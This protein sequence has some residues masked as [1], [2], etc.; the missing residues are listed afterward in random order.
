[1]FIFF[2]ALSKFLDNNANESGNSQQHS[3]R[4]LSQKNPFSFAAN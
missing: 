2:A 3:Q 4:S 1:M